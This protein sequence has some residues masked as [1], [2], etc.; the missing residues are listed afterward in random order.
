MNDTSKQ[1]QG[2]KLSSLQRLTFLKDHK[3]TFSFLHY[4]EK[5]IREN[6][7]EL[8]NFVLELKTTFPAAKVSIEQL[9][10]DCAIFSASIKNIDSSLQNGNLS[11]SSTFHPEDKFLKTVLRGLPNARVKS[12]LLKDR[13][14]F[15]MEKFDKMMKYFGEDP[16][17]DEFVRNSFF[18]KFSDFIES[19][20][21][22]SK[23]N[24]EFEERN[25][26]YELSL[27]KIEQQKVKQAKKEAEGATTSKSSDMEKFLQQLRQ[28]GTTR[29]Q[30]SSAKIRQWAKKHATGKASTGEDGDTATGAENGSGTSAEGNVSVDPDASNISLSS[31]PDDDDL[32]SK[33]QD[34]LFKLTRQATG[35]D[36]GTATASGSA[37]GNASGASTTVNGSASDLQFKVSDFKLSDRMRKRLQEKGQGQSRHSSVSS[38]D[39][40]S[41]LLKNDDGSSSRVSKLE[42]TKNPLLEEDEEDDDG[43]V[44]DAVVDLI[45]EP[46]HSYMSSKVDLDSDDV[47][48]KDE[49]EDAME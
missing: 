6:Y 27:R 41:L 17:A 38:I 35:D 16:N 13:A 14:Q 45:S 7:P 29:A 5:I 10:Q 11:D 1:A 9:K 40:E 2:F 44:S 28:T 23:E 3:N 25:R 37:T 19:F 48:S 47:H 18:R 43:G 49:F 33:T 36:M 4:V 20:E 32:R 46:S 8:L 15:T 22:V 30:P 24:K 42:V 39:V 26:K 34:L 31:V 12:D 21:K